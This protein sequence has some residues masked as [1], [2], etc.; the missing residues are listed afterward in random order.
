VKVGLG[1]NIKEGEAIATILPNDA[2]LA[3]E[4]FVKPMDF[5]L[6]RTGQPVRL[7]FDGWPALVF[8]GWPNTS[9][10]TFAG[11][12]AVINNVATN[13]KYRI[14]VTPD[15]QQEPWPEALR[16]GSGVYGW[17]L[18]QDVPIW[19]ELWRQLNGFPADYTGDGGQVA[20]AKTKDKKS[21]SKT[22]ETS[23]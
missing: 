2:H 20:D 4:L 8:S 21:E 19:Y 13:G 17:A 23:E 12:I 14:L 16:I 10:G 5:P 18:L 3:V 15:P 6:I 11:R 9:F 7:Q 22:D 1:E